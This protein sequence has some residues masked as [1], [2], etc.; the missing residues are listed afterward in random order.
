MGAWDSESCEPALGRRLILPRGGALGVG[1]TKYPLRARGRRTAVRLA[2]R[3]KI[4]LLAAQGFQNQQIAQQLSVTRQLVARQRKR[5]LQAGVAGI[6]KDAP[7]A[8]RKPAVGADKVREIV[9]LT[10]Q[11]TPSN[12][13]HWSRR[14]MA[15]H[16]GLSPSTVGRIWRV[17]G[18][19]P[20]LVR[21]FK[22][23]N[24]PLFAEK[25]D[26]MVGLYWNPPEHA[27][28]LSLDE[29]SQM[30]AL[31]R[32]QPGL[33]LKKGR[34]QTMTHDFKRNGT[35]TLLAALN[36]LDGRV[37]GTCRPRHTH[38]EWL[39]FLRLIE[40]RTA[41]DK[42]LHLIVDNYATHKHKAVK[43]R[44]RRHQRVHLHFPPT[45]ASWLNRV[46]RFL[47]DL[48]DQRIRRGAFRS[49]GELHAAIDDYLA[50]HNQDP[51]PFI[52]TAKASDILEKVKRGRAA[53]PKL[54]S[55]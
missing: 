42:Q 53:L 3:A 51:K 38:K 29:K 22:L 33:P 27:L 49:V 36:T 7:R 55:A 39:R 43:R 13:T 40:R 30:Q 44:L 37:T 18:L 32:T 35:T 20:H 41:P 4:V 8:G 25:L 26:D 15:R 11:Q 16:S 14:N 54:Q 10:T 48:T 28:V 19:K 34:G 47:R 24:D 9:R 17:H 45:S 21:T 50:I 46:E 5:F 2:L 52:W 1:G 6:E 23:S 31:D 12:A